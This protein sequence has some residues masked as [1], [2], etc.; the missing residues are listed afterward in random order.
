[1]RCWLHFGSHVSSRED[2]LRKGASFL[3]LTVENMILKAKELENI[4]NTPCVFLKPYLRMSP[5]ALFP[6]HPKVV[7]V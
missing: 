4:Q 6:P 2:G 3:S 7:P 1:M 5:R